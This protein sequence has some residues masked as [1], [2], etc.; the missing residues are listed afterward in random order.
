MRQDLRFAVRQLAKSPGTTAVALLTLTLAIGA[1]TAIFSVVHAVLLR[2]LP[3]PEPERLVTIWDTFPHWRTREI[4]S[5]YWDR[6]ALA[7][8]EYE[9]L[10][11]GATTFDGV[12]IY[13]ARPVTVSGRGE[14]EVVRG[15]LATPQLLDVLGVDPARGRWFVAAES[16]P[17]APPVAV[18]RHE[19]WTTRL[20]GDQGVI[21][22]SVRVDGEAHVIVG[23]LPRGFRFGV[24]RAAAPPEI[25][26]AAGRLPPESRNEGNHSFEAVG[27][28]APGVSIEQALADVTPL[29][30]GERSAES[31]GARVLPRLEE[32]VGASRPG[33]LLLFVSVGLVLLVACV[34]LANL[35]LGQTAGRDRE[36]AIRLALG[37]GRARVARLL[38]IESALLGLLG[39]AAG[40]G[41]AWLGV[42]ALATVLPA[43]TPRLDE[44]AVH[45]PALGYAL[46]I[47]LAASALFGLAPTLRLARS[48][49][50]GQLRAGTRASGGHR[51]QHA[52]IAV[53]IALAVVL[54]IGGGLLVRS[55]WRVTAVDPGFQTEALLTFEVSPPDWRY[56]TPDRIEAFFAELEAGLGALPGVSGVAA[57]STLPLS[58]RSSS[59][60]VRIPSLGMDPDGPSLEAERRVVTPSY[61]GVMGIPLERGRLIA[62]SDDA[63]G[64]RAVVVSHTAAERLW[65]GRDPIGDELVANQQRWTVVGIVADVK[66]RGPG[67][68]AESTVYYPLAQYPRSSLTMVARTAL[69]PL[70]LAPAARAVVAALDPE[71]PVTAV[72]AMAELARAATSSERHR[73]V[74]VGAF[75]LLALVLASVGIYGVTAHAVETRVGEIGVR[76]ALGADAWRIRGLVLGAVARV[77]AVGVTAGLALAALGGRLV[78]RFLFGVSAFD[79]ATYGAV[80]AAIVAVVVL[81]AGV[82]AERAASVSP[83]DALRAE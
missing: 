30:R 42:R 12:A 24:V 46:G 66:H 25:W 52:L 41:L 58:G 7:W 11:D 59:T 53:E 1:N 74:L 29:L 22:Q 72:Q 28:L 49:A 34:N 83:A 69:P 26:T 75:A 27:R 10:R 19:Y 82:P 80:L 32:E 39:A 31:L 4:L 60:S 55:L 54:L 76:V 48:R 63:S 36:I 8:P 45:L 37:A 43:D 15:G 67:E 56:E 38:L 14:P 68:D 57:T 16:R 77:A 44:V 73:A 3:W 64:A 40:A 47:A 81:S 9:R 33:L 65:G 6:I 5:Q 51:L 79:P 21:G 61:F 20:G 18:I 78:E 35:K 62:A 23:I 17:G 71:L 13:D 2:P 70:D 50:I